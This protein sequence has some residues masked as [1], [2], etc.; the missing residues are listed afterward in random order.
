M[1]TYIYIYRERESYTYIVIYIESYIFRDILYT[2]R[3][4]IE[5]ELPGG[6]TWAPPCPSARRHR[7][8]AVLSAVN[9][10]TTRYLRNATAENMTI[11][12]RYV[13]FFILK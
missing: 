7:P 2:Y 13:Y 10:R 3:I 1:Y 6:A 9:G 8:L 4:S 5:R 11:V 12:Y